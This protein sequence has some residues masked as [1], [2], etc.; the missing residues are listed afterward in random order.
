MAIKIGTASYGGKNKNFFKLKDGDSIF[1]ILPPLGEMAESGRWS[2]FWNVHYGYKNSAGKLRVFQSPLVKDRKT[3]MVQVPDAALERIEQLKARLE[4]AKASGDQKTV[5][6]LGKLVGLPPKVMGQFNLDNNH[7]VNAID[8]QGNI[9]VLKLRHRAKLALDTAIKALRD[10]GVDPLSVNDGRYFV[11]RRSGT[12]LDTS[13]QVFPFQNERVIE[14]VGKVYVDV[15]HKLTDDIINRLEREAGQ[16]NKL[17][18]CP[19]AEEV[20]RIV[21]EGPKAVDEIFDSVGGEDTSS[22]EGFEDDVPV[23]TTSVAGTVTEPA[24]PVM[25]RVSEHLVPQP[26]MVAAPVAPVAAPVSMVSTSML[27]G[28]AQPVAANTP[29]PMSAPPATT[30]QT[31]S[32]MYNEDFLKSL[33]L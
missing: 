33:G 28:Y 32:E 30:E 27:S 2:V 9:G 21:K 31:V 26:S 1:R 18:K 4:Q 3:K 11:F 12:S 15:V 8:Q 14:G 7:Y 17:F 23:G 13:F 20:A 19:T 24:S 29:S 6:A 5:E 22:D 25:P 10:K 16:L